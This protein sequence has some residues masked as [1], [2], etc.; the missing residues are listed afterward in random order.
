MAQ[1]NVTISLPS[2]VIKEARHLAVDKGLS[3]SKFLALLLEEHIEAKR[4]YN[5][6]REEALKR[7]EAAREEALKLMKEGLPLGTHGKISWTRD[8]L[9]ER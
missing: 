8:E 9:H 6:D 2:D 1:Q 5:A 4:Q 3:L 7:Y